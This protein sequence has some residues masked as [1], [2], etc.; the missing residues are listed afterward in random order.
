MRN[1]LCVSF[2]LAAVLLAGRSHFLP[3]E[4]PCCEK[5][6]KGVGVE[7]CLYRRES[8]SGDRVCDR[9]PTARDH[10]QALQ[11]EMLSCGAFH[12]L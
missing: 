10:A 4:Q 1:L 2:L 8:G 3:K 11:E 7:V 5:I 6:A 9:I 12:C